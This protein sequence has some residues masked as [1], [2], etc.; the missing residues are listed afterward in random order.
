MPATMT[1]EKV[2]FVSPHASLWVS[3]ETAHDDY[4]GPMG[5]RRTIQPARKV[6]FV[7]GRAW[8]DADFAEEMRQKAS[9]GT[10]FW[11]ADDIMAPFVGDRDPKVVSGQQHSIS[12]KAA[13]PPLANWDTLTAAQLK[14]AVTAGKVRDL[15]AALVWEAGHRNRGQ[16]VLAIS[17]AMSGVDPTDDE[18]IAAD[19]VTQADGFVQAVP[20]DAKGLG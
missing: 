7:K 20:A 4:S 14:E 8:V 9:Y 17:K 10:L 18:P 15:P 3:I 1:A 19:P 16:V 5:S 11:A 12:H 2:E 6:Q 13:G